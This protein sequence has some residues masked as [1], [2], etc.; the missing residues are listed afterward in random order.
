MAIGA[1]VLNRVSVVRS[2]EF[3]ADDDVTIAT[4]RHFVFDQQFGDF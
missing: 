1:A 2:D 4:Q 3:L